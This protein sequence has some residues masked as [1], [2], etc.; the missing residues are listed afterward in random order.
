MKKLNYFIMALSL[1]VWIFV[2]IRDG[3]ALYT[4]WEWIAYLLGFYAFAWFAIAIFC[5]FAGI[6]F[7]DDHRAKLESNYFNKIRNGLTMAEVKSLMGE[8]PSTISD[9][10]G[11]VMFQYKD[12][13]IIY[14]FFFQNGL[15]TKWN[16]LSY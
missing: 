10:E 6:D 7:N 16:R 15:L 4:F 9:S 8:C 3:W 2:I 5:E 13:H 11:N 12:R 14:K 1:G